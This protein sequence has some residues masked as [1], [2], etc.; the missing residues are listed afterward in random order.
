[1]LKYQKLLK[2][3][4]FH[5]LVKKVQRPLLEVFGGRANLLIAG[6]AATKPEV[7]KFYESLGMTFI[8]GYGMTETVGPI[9]ISKRTKKRVPFAF[10]A[11]EIV[12]P[13]PLDA[14]AEIAGFFDRVFILCR[15][16]Q[17][18]LAAIFFS[19]WFLRVPVKAAF[20]FRLRFPDAL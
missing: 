8:Q 18:L 11:R 14:G 19:E 13:Q 5:W 20:V 2:K 4:G 15:Q 17:N 3:I 7:E 1:M 16:V 9:C 6:G 12:I 10:G